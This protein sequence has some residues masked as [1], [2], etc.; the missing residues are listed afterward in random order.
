MLIIENDVINITKG[1]DGAVNVN[2]SVGG[3]AYEMAANDILTLTVREKPEA[4]SPA[5]ITIHSLPGR[6]RIVIDSGATAN[7]EPGKYSADIQ[8]TTEDGRIHTV[9]PELEGSARYR[10][11]NWGNFIIMPEVTTAWQK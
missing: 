8:L 6:S 5:L 3:E 7:L 1:D 2:V 9:W 11:K 10:V 4:A